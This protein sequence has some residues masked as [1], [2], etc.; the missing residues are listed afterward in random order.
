MVKVVPKAEADRKIRSP[1]DYY[2]TMVRNGWQLLKVIMLLRTLFLEHFLVHWFV[3][4][5]YTFSS[6][7]QSPVSELTL[8]FG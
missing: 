1:K 6:L 3:C 5:E 2:F 8:P 4:L 7:L